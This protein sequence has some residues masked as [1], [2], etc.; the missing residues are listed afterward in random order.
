M[1]HQSYWAEC[2]WPFWVQS[3]PVRGISIP[4]TQQHMRTGD[5]LPR[6]S[7][8]RGRGGTGSQR[9]VHTWCF[10]S[11]HPSPFFLHSSFWEALLCHSIHARV[12]LLSPAHRGRESSNQSWA[13]QCTALPGPQW[14]VQECTRVIQSD[15]MR[16][17]AF[18]EN[19]GKAIFSLHLRVMGGKSRSGRFVILASRPLSHSWHLRLPSWCHVEQRPLSPQRSVQI[20]DLPLNMIAVVLSH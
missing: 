12:G 14:L 20:T 4:C 15:S 16:C 9:G 11:Q 7:R 13:N 19:L 2:R 10:P 6:E 17:E 1:L 18:A 3:S 8:Q 5:F